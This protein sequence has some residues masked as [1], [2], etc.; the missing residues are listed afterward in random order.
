MSDAT[1]SNAPEGATVPDL[2]MDLRWVP[3]GDLRDAEGGNPNEM[4]DDEFAALVASITAEGLMYPVVA[5]PVRETSDDGAALDVWEIIDGHHRTKAL[6]QIGAA[7]VPVLAVDKDFDRTVLLQIGLNK[8]R[9]HINL[10]IAG[11]KLADLQKEGVSLEEMTLT[12][13]STEEIAD[14][15]TAATEDAADILR[16]GPTSAPSLVEDEPAP[17]KPFVL[18]VS[19]TDREQYQAARKGLK[20][21]AGKGGDLALGLLRILGIED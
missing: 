9:G 13:Y 6:R 12:G 1:E 3:I 2:K 17:P 15:I 5:R 20:K 14:M 18:E 8:L 16:S 19:F 7:R 21:A 11:E 10:A 4:N